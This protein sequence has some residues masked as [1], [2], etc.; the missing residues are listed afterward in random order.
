MPPKASGMRVKNLHSKSNTSPGSLRFLNTNTLAK[1]W[2]NPSDIKEENGEI[3]KCG[4]SIN[5][6]LLTMAKG[7]T[8]EFRPF[9]P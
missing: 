7:L 5:V 1:L 3:Q 4:R 8:L 9:L 2:F 6:L